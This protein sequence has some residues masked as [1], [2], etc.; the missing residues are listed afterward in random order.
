M[1][2]SPPLPKPTK[3]EYGATIHFHREPEVKSVGVTEPVAQTPEAAFERDPA[4]AIAVPEDL[5]I[6]HPVL[7]QQREYWQ[8]VARREVIGN[9]QPTSSEYPHLFKVQ[10]P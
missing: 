4:N 8:A 1:K 10:S 7:R 3:P 5:R 2:A 6:T 9:G